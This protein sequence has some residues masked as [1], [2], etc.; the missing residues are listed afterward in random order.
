LKNSN[1]RH[2]NRKEYQNMN[3]QFWH[4]TVGKH[5]PQILESKVIK[6]ATEGIRLP[7]KPAAWFSTN[8]LWE[9]TCRK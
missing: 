7:E 9:P 2:K 1:D 4:Y 8:S 3:K 6:L 5:L